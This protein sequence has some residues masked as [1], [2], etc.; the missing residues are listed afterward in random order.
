MSFF[1]GI[2]GKKQ[3]P[4]QQQQPAASNQ[5]NNNPDPAPAAQ[6][7]PGT[8]PNGTVPPKDAADANKD[9]NA[10]PLAKFEKLWED[11]PPSDKDDQQQNQGLTP[12]QM[13]E[14]A[15]K[16]DF[17]RVVDQESLRKI[18][19]GGEEA[20]TALVNLLNKTSQQVYG[21]STV[22]AQK[23]IERAVGD[24][25]TRFASR[26]PDLVRRQSARESLI[27]ENPAFNDPAV[28]GI[29]GM[30]QNQLAAKFP[31]ATSSEIKAMAQEYFAGAAQKLVP[32]SGK[33]SAT[34]GSKVKKREDDVD[35]DTW[36]NTPLPGSPTDF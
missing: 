7:P 14:A 9:A 6:N 3:E 8:A 20:A 33:S 4:Q 23:L 25:E 15:S 30:V 27:T 12:Q 17:S 22:V 10:S 36:L 35:W 31:Q 29:V 28:S 32:G 34:G 11:T 19:A 21:Q 5:P 18:V 1:E 24:A 2:F 13:M 26:V 16:V